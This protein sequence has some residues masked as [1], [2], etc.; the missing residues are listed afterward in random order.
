VEGGGGRIGEKNR[1]FY[2][3]FSSPIFT[4]SSIVD[5]GIE[6]KKKELWW[7]NEGRFSTISFF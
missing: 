6:L 4:S 5:R 7:V 2:F 3:L 1:L